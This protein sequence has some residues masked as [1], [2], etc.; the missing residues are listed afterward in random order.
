M[1]VHRLRKRVAGEASA[2]FKADG[3]EEARKLLNAF[4][5]RWGKELPQA[6]EVL[7]NGFGA[8]TQFYAFPRAHWT[9]LR[10]TNGLERLHREVKRR[11]KATGAFPDRA[12][13]LRLVTAV[14][15]K[16]AE[17]WRARRYLDVSL[18]EQEDAKAA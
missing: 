17:V 2:M 10:T 11:I 9:R 4:R 16:A 7:A 18:L 12:S 13:A 1:V 3:L 6:V 8:A 14:A 5:A 15:L